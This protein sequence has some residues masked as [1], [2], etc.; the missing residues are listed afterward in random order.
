MN[1]IVVHVG[2]LGFTRIRFQTRIPT[3]SPHCVAENDTIQTTELFHCFCCACKN[4]AFCLCLACLT[5]WMCVA[6]LLEFRW[7][8]R[9]SSQSSLLNFFST[10]PDYWTFS[11]FLLHV[12]NMS[13]CLCFGLFDTL[14][15]CPKFVGLRDPRQKWA[16][17]RSARRRFRCGGHF[18]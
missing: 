3:R 6:I 1:V 9:W 8:E 18:W 4:V 17:L 2:S 13:F 14:N 5:R 7:I 11:L 15:I 10:N 16:E 12:R